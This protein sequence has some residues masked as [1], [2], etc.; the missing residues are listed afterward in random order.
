MGME[1]IIGQMA[2]FITEIG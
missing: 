2:Q 1:Y